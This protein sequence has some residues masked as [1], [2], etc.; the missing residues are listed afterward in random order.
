[1]ANPVGYSHCLQG[2][3]EATISL[4]YMEREMSKRC[5]HSNA[6]TCFSLASSA[7]RARGIISKEALLMGTWNVLVKEFGVIET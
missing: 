3:D 5:R 1:M 4:I 6:T 2:D 7:W